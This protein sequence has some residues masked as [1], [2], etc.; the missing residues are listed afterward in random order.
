MA[1]IFTK[2]RSIFTL[3]QHQSML[4]HFNPSHHSKIHKISSLFHLQYSSFTSSTTQTKQE[5]DT[6]TIIEPQYDEQL[7]H[8]FDPQFDNLIHGVWTRQ[9]YQQRQGR[10]E[11]EIEKLGRLFVYQYN[12][13]PFCGKVKAVLDYYNIPYSLIEVNPMTK[14]QLPNHNKFLHDRNVPILLA[15]KAQSGPNKYHFD[16]KVTYKSNVVIATILENLCLNGLMPQSEY[17]RSQSSIIDAWQEWMD[18]N[19]IPHLYIAIDYDSYNVSY[20]NKLFNDGK[21]RQNEENSTDIMFRYL[22]EFKKFESA[23]VSTFP[24]QQICAQLFH[25]QAQQ[26]R[27]KYGVIKDQEMEQLKEVLNE[28]HHVTKVSF[29][30][31]SKPDLADL[32][33]FGIL[34]TF[35]NLPLITQLIVI[36]LEEQVLI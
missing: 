21:N 6:E 22:K 9:D 17:E 31:G 28:W 16:Q 5:D 30:G 33:C 12:C 35:N 25:N 14:S 32:M 18:N 1:P 10:P 19:L 34:R 29:H 24:I 13:C 2:I 23:G 36:E 15:A 7:E 4:H 20:I 26:L 8:T 3:H 11:S 27:F